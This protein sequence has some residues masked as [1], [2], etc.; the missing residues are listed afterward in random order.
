MGEIETWNP[1]NEGN[2]QIKSSKLFR[3]YGKNVGKTIIYPRFLRAAITSAYRCNETESVNDLLSQLDWPP[4]S[5]MRAEELARKLV[6]SIRG[7][8]SHR[9]GVD[10][11]MHEFSL[12]SQEGIALMCLA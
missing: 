7:K 11:L 6:T 3:S 2:R 9:G 10:A 8:Y 4:R 12:S 1:G 5:R